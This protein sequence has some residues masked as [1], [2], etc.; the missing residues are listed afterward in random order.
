MTTVARENY[1]INDWNII[2]KEVGLSNL[3][4]VFKSDNS[5]NWAEDK[6]E[7]AGV[8]PIKVL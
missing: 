7:G 1:T 3:N 2:A 4:Q 8:V 5:N 6:E